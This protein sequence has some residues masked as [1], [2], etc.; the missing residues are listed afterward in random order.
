MNEDVLT[1]ELAAVREE[2]HLV[3][4]LVGLVLAG[5]WAGGNAAMISAI[6]ALMAA[7]LPPEKSAATAQEGATRFNEYFAKVTAA[8]NAASEE[9]LKQN[10]S[11]AE[12]AKAIAAQLK[13]VKDS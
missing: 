3:R 7:R 8:V 9:A 2:L 4:L 10:L 5:T 11:D 13:D 1:K 6:A 12:T